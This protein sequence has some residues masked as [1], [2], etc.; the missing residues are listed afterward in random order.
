MKHYFWI[1]FKVNL[2]KMLE[3]KRSFLISLL[4]TIATQSSFLLAWDA[5][6][7][8]SPLVAGWSFKDM[9]TMYGLVMLSKGMIEMF[10]YGLKL[11]PRLIENHQLDVFLLQPKSLIFSI[12]F[13][14]LDLESLA[15]VFLGFCLIGYA[16][17][18]TNPLFWIV[19]PFVFLFTFSL[20]LY[21]N[22]LRFFLSDSTSFLRELITSA[23]I[24]LSQPSSAYRGSLK[25]F[26]MTLLPAAFL[27]FFPVEF[28]RT[29]LLEYFI[30]TAVGNTLFFFGARAL[31]YQG[32]KRY[33]SGSHH[34]ARQ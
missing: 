4:L 33:E 32:L 20:Y 2:L 16:G 23:S 1:V 14:K 24:A 28:L 5:F 17:H 6:F 27:S 19:L 13:T 25:F 12:A 3:S 31:F 34:I 15:E 11:M 8:K 21:I 29:A 7:N 10:F 18:L 9:A 30:W 22:S 26:L